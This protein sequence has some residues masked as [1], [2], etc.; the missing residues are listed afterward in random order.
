VSGAHE[1]SAL[2]A[3]PRGEAQ[4][5]EVVGD[6]LKPPKVNGFIEGEATACLMFTIGSDGDRR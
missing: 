1:G 2:V 3:P 5:A 6:K 4:V